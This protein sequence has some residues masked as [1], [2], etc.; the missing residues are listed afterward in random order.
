MVE[1]NRTVI[2]RLVPAEPIMRAREALEGLPMTLN[3]EEAA[4]WLHDSRTGFKDG[5]CAPR[6]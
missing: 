4:R 3:A 5:L 2:A 1:R 6:A